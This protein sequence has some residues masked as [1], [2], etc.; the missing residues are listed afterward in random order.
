MEGQGLAHRTSLNSLS[1]S[2]GYGPHKLLQVINDVM[3]W[4][5]SVLLNW[6]VG[7]KNGQPLPLEDRKSTGNRLEVLTV[8]RLSAR[9]R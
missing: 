7:L 6:Q 3:F 1:G 2:H 5:P 8:L 4:R 9:Q